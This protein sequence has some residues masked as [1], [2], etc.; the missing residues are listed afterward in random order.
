[1]MF[2]RTNGFFSRLRLKNIEKYIIRIG[3]VLAV[4]VTAFGLYHHITR[5]SLP[6]LDVNFGVS[7]EKEINIAP[8]DDKYDFMED[9]NVLPAGLKISNSGGQAAKNVVLKIIPKMLTGIQYN[10][11][12]AEEQNYS[13]EKGKFLQ[14]YRLDIGTINQGDTIY[15][16]KHI[17]AEIEKNWFTNNLEHLKVITK[18]G[19]KIAFDPTK[20]KWSAKSVIDVIMSAENMGTCKKTITLTIGSPEYFKS[21]NKTFY[22]MKRVQKTYSN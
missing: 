10:V 5:P 16:T 22:F 8:A 15:L 9:M 2:E 3:G 20:W 18:D 1:M 17:Y 7:N 19:K 14:V 11:V 21:D 6:V 4:L 13:D 12:G